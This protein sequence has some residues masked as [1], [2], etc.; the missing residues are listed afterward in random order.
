VGGEQKTNKSIKSSKKKKNAFK[1]TSQM[2]ASVAE[3]RKRDE[4]RGNED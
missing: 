3:K 4:W 1:C 2:S